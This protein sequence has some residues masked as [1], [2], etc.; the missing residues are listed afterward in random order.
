M[1]TE[2]TGKGVNSK[3]LSPALEIFILKRKKTKD[4]AQIQISEW[5]VQNLQYFP[6]CPY[7]KA[8]KDILSFQDVV[9]KTPQ[10]SSSTHIY[11]QE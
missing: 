6:S 9:N 1:C 2:D 5:D 11:P 8:K 7:L 3:S 4:F 10:L